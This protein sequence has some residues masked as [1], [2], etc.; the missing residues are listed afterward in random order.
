MGE[1]RGEGSEMRKVACCRSRGGGHGK[2]SR[3]AVVLVVVVVRC[4]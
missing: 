4:G 1:E 3:V 2:E